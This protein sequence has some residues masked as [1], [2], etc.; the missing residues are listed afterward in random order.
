M[1]LVS[2][3]IEQQIDQLLTSTAGMELE[4]AKVQFRKQLTQIIIDAIKSAT[5]TV[6]PGVIQVAGSP[7]AQSNVAPIVISNSIS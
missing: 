7:S 3:T 5:I 4:Q 6:Q 1:A 2:A